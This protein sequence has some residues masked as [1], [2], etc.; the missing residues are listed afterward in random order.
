MN[1]IN[2]KVR[3]KNPVFLAHLG[4][5][6]FVPILGYFGL[7]AQ[8][9]TTWKAV[10]DLVVDAVS[11]PYVVGLIVVSVWN[12]INDPTTKGLGDSEQAQ[13]YNLPK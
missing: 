4:L 2:W 5:S 11:N 12:A 10:L 13:Q 8:D 3:F 6:I 9:L 1:K 7:T